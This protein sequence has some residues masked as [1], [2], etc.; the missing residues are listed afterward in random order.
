M[1]AGDQDAQGAVDDVGQ[2]PGRDHRVNEPFVEEVL[3]R[4]DVL[5][6]RRAV[7]GLVDPGS[8]EAEQGSGFGGGDVAE[9]SPRGHDASRGGVPQ[10]DQVG[11]PGLSVGPD[12]RADLH[13]G[14][15]RDGS[16][17]HAGAAR[18]RPGEQGQA[19]T[20]GP[21]DGVDDPFRRGLADGAGEEPELA[22][23]HRDPA[24]ADEA[25][26]GEDGFVHAGLCPGGGQF[27]PVLG[28]GLRVHE[29]RVPATVGPGVEH[30]GEEFGGVQVPDFLP[31]QHAG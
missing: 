3:G 26:A 4:L 7:E 24:A 29:G 20:G 23:D 14:Q 27:L 19:L 11:Q 15:E 2:L 31:G 12:G 13:H 16:F 8:E 30:R 1:R 28:T 18:G 22:D 25:F 10:V 21:F 9:G 17:L 5:R 6:E